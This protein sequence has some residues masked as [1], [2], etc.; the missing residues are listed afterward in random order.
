MA[1]QPPGLILSVSSAR[2]TRNATP[3]P[4]D[5]RRPAEPPRY[6][7]LPV[8]ISLTVWPTYTLYVSMNHAITCSFV[9]MSGPMMSVCGPTKGIISCM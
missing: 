1:V 8:T 4:V 6:T 9:P 5:S 2:S 7:G 3:R